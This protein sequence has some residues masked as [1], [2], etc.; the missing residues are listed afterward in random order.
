MYLTTSRPDITFVVSACARFQVT[1]KI[2]H[3]HD[4]KRIF[5]YLKGQPKLGLWYHMDSPFDLEAFSDSDY[6]GASLDR[7]STTG[8]TDIAKI[9]RKRSKPDNHEHGNGI[10]NTRAGRMLSKSYTSSNALIGQYPKGNDTRTMDEAHK[11]WG[12]YTKS[13]LKE[14]Q[15]PLTHGCHVGNP[16][17]PQ[18]NP[19]MEREHPMIEGMKGQDLWEH[20]PTS[21]A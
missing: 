16:C 4:V 11:E 1:P 2:S 13:C 7:K 14:A 8:G 10:E 6:A 19:T 3:L 9:S 12:C 5:R 17:A 20:L 21:K 18:S 15:R